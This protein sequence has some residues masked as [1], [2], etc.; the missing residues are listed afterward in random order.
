MKKNFGSAPKWE[1]KKLRS[2][3]I[4]IGNNPVEKHFCRS[5][6][7]SR[8]NFLKYVSCNHP[9]SEQLI[10]RKASYELR[11]S[12]K[13]VDSM[14]VLN[15]PL[16]YAQLIRLFGKL[17]DVE[18]EQLI[19]YIICSYYPIDNKELLS[20]FKSYEAMIAAMESTTGDDHDINETRDDFSFHAFAE[21][22]HYLQMEMPSYAIRKVT[23]FPTSRK[24]ELLNELRLHTAASERQIRQFLHIK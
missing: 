11:K 13:E 19:D 8:W 3:I 10:K 18:I 9:F 16:K 5:A 22:S 1:E 2:S 21:M 14:S 15:R 17:S 6:G 7:E 23:T 24:L 20:H 12:L 4:Y